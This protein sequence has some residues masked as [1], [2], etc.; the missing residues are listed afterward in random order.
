MRNS[1]SAQRLRHH[2]GCPHS[3]LGASVQVPGLLEFYLAVKV[4]PSRHQWGLRWLGPC[5]QGGRPE[6]SPSS[7]RY[8][9]MNQLMEDLH[10]H[11]S[12]SLF[13]SNKIK[14]YFF[15]FKDKILT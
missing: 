6:L 1:L 2:L 14:I 9:G 3:T 4:H 12:V 11:L 8:L 15:I 5:C 10:L 7:F 13:L